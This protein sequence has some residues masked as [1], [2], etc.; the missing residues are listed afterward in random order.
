MHDIERELIKVT[1]YKP[2]RKFSDREDYLKSLL[3]DVMKLTDADF[4]E[5]TDE[6]AAWTN[7]AV[8]AH[9]SK[10]VAIP[11]FDEVPA[12]EDETDD[13]AV[14]E[15]SE[16]DVDSDSD[17]GD[18][19]GTDESDEV[20]DEP[21]DDVE[22][23]PAPKPSKKK[24]KA[25][26]PVE[27]ED[28]PEGEDEGPSEEDLEAA[29]SDAPEDED[30]PVPKPAKKKM[31]AKEKTKFKIPPKPKVTT[32]AVKPTKEVN[33][34]DEEDVVLDKWGCMEGSKNSRAL[35]MFERG[36]TTKE[37]KDAIG[38]TYYNILG[39]CEK[40]GHKLEK[41]GAIIK[42]THR[43]ANKAPVKKKK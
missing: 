37:V 14:E 8:D 7:A 39:K 26:A 1:G 12:S 10:D 41:D 3:N 5:L 11:D 25:S 33:P 2:K 29:D 34:D 9:N 30:E 43:D 18:E 6:A 32:L 13:E 42:L 16:E 40:N 20:E 35:A 38:G 28:D 22:E 36:A 23:E 17:D 24:V 15:A 19:E 21:E 27:D 4:D 31:V